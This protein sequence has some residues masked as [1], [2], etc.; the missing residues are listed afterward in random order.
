[1]STA[2][3]RAVSRRSFL[4]QSLAGAALLSSTAKL[5]PAEAKGEAMRT[6]GNGAAQLF[7]D[8]RDVEKLDNVR[9]TFHSAEKH[10]ANPVLCGEYHWERRNG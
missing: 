9:Q 6:V 2:R 8:L 3:S 4:R 7:V 5:L 10:S 1:M